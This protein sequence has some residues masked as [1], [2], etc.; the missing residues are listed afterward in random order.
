MFNVDRNKRKETRKQTEN[1][2]TANPKQKQKESAF[3]DC[4]LLLV[5]VI[6]HDNQSNLQKSVSS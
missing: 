2:K 4:K 3:R 6:K 1:N 5:A